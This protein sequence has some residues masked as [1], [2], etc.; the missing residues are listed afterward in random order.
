M[1]WSPAQVPD[2]EFKER[3]E[4]EFIPFARDIV[5]ALYVQGFAAFL[6]DNRAA[7]P[8]AVPPDI[9][10]YG[11]RVHS[12][13][14]RRSFLMF[15]PGL[16]EP[17][18]KAMFVVENWPSRDGMPRSPVAAYRRT[19]AFRGMVELNTATADYSA[20]RPMLYTSVDSDKAF[21]K[22]HVYRNGLDASIDAS[23]MLTHLREVTGEH[24]EAVQDV[25]RRAHEMLIGINSASLDNH[26]KHERSLR[27]A[28]DQQSQLVADL[29]GGRLDPRSVRL[30]PGTGLPVFDSALAQR[31]GDAYNVFPLPVDAKVQATVVP[32]S[33]SD[34]VSIFNNA[35]QMACIAMGVPSSEIGMADGQRFAP[36][37]QLS[38]GVLQNTLS[39]FRTVLSRCLVDVYTALYGEHPGLQARAPP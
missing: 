15:R 1:R 3:V 28:S 19:H 18:R 25:H 34:L 9:C 12:A 5:D 10:T 13:S 4:R 2:R 23:G 36:D 16:I 32:V 7:L 29:N 14:M 37:A 27:V 39:R 26:A 30:D 35:S 33:R 20:A 21:D 38:G 6:V 11:I 22:R 8:Y 24:D 17:E 31:P